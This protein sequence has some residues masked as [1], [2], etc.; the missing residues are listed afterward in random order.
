MERNFKSAIKI[1]GLKKEY[2]D[3][4]LGPVDLDVPCGFVTAIIG[5]NGAGKSTLLDILGGIKTCKNGKVT[6][7]EH[8]TDL[9]DGNA[10]NEIGWCAG[11]R[12]FPENWTLKNVKESVSL[13]FNNFNMEKFDA[14][15]QSFNLKDDS[16]EKRQK[17]IVEYSD[18]N[19]SRLAIASVLARDTKLLILDEPDSAL[20]PVIRDTL[21]SKFR[22]YI[23]NGDGETSILFSTHNVADMESIVDYVVYLSYGKV[24]EQGFVQDL[25]EEYRYVHGPK[26]L[27]ESHKGDL[28]TFYAGE[29]EQYFEGLCK[30]GTENVFASDSEIAVEAPTLQQLSVLMLRKWA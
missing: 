27:L 7:L 3:F 9:D 13:A 10:R 11:N 1:E 2:K 14:V 4:S 19:K 17:K 15:C 22:Q 12:Y 5:E 16:N 29:D 28:E 26:G 25:L 30:T 6:W 18:G 23:N 21:C 20:D 8:Y 24:V